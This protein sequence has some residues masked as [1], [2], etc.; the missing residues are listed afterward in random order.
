MEYKDFIKEKHI[1][2]APCGMD[3]DNLADGLFDYQHAVVRWAL[4][5]GRAAIFG[6]T[7]TGKT[8][9]ELAWAD[10]VYKE[11]GKNVLILAPLAVAAQIKNEAD[12][13]YMIDVTHAKSQNDVREG[14]NVTNYDKLDKFDLSFFDAIVLDE[15][16]I[17][18][19]FNG[20]TRDNIIQSFS[21]YSYR[22]AATAT[23]AP[24]DFMEL[25]NHAEFLGVMS[26]AEMLAMFFVHDGGETQKWRLKGHAKKDF[27]RWMAQ[28]SV[29]FN[30]P[31]DL[32]FDGASHVL[33]PL[34]EHN[35]VVDS[36]IT[37]GDA[38]FRFEAQTLQE[39]IRERKFST[40]E[41][42]IAAIDLIGKIFIIGSTGGNAQC[43][44]QNTQKQEKKNTSQTHQKESEE[45]LSQDPLM[46]TGNICVNTT[47]KTNINGQKRQENREI[48][49]TQ[50]DAKSTEHAKKLEN[51]A[52][53]HQNLDLKKKDGKLE[54]RKHTDY[55]N[56]NMKQC[57]INK[58]VNLFVAELNTSTRQESGLSLTTATQQEKLE[59]FCALPAI[60]RLDFLKKAL[61]QCETQQYIFQEADRWVIWCGLNSEQDFIANIL[62]DF[63]YSINGS[64]S[65]KDKEEALFGWTNG[66][67]PF[68]ISKVKIFGFG[69]N[70][71]H[72]RN[73]I[74]VGLNDSWEQVYQAIR[75]CWR[76]GQKKEVNV[77]YISSSLEGNVVKNLERK[78]TQAEEMMQAMIEE[79]KDFQNVKAVATESDTATYRRDVVKSDKFT[80]HLGDCVDV[81]GEIESDSIGYCIYSPPFASLY[82]YSNSDRDMGNCKTH[83]EF[84][85]HYKYLVA[86]LY[87]VMKPGRLISFHCMNL[88]T[89]K[90]KDGVIGIRDFRGELIR[91][92]E[93]AGFIYHSEV[94]IWK[95]P[96]TAMQRTKAIG[97][98]HKQLKKD[99][100]LSRQGIPDYLVTVRKPGDND[101]PIS[102]TNEDFPVD[103]WQ[104]YASPVWMDINPSDTL[105]YKSAREHDDERHICPLQLEVIRRGIDL[106]SA[107]GDV[108]LSPFMGIGSEGYIALQKGRKFI[109]AELKESYWK[110]AVANLQSVQ[111]EQE[112][113]LFSALEVNA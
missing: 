101:T 70:F 91:M 80:A 45:N 15:S 1:R 42:C 54:S 52:Y 79:M 78:N 60:Q 65:E 34:K 30:S 110:Q 11:T 18:K 8:F 58:A 40:E 62:G 71:Q 43:G 17:L 5:K 113:S 104:K 35:I 69:M 10:A 85:D 96:V 32:G 20:K 9:M 41:R 19:S 37:G 99:S 36:D 93:E 77:Y 55:Q 29:M 25:G 72:C 38:L 3:V 92:H 13:I 23:P 95:D 2:V 63:C 51:T 111:H 56:K 4:K 50:I 7:G 103:L 108:V 46:K 73:M 82:T 90:A 89:S 28:W 27:W 98:L 105:Q 102:H 83:D 68:L 61:K 74:F 87:R 75:R 59:A 88:P 112:N 12:T 84:Y 22:L 107:E 66:N 26:Y 44:S 67:R 76:F 97:L 86:E 109:G 106:W 64:S 48:C 57:F 31:Y 24:N 6:G 39:R 21:R 94:C 16:S 14:I 33:P 49:T 81:V 100:A 53:A 47:Q